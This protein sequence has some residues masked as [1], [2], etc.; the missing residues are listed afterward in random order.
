M[1]YLPKLDDNDEIKRLEA[2]ICRWGG[3]IVDYHEAKSYQIKPNILKGGLGLSEFYSG[4]VYNSM[5]I[6]ES[7]A[8]GYVLDSAMFLLTTLDQ[9]YQVKT[10]TIAKRKKFTIMEGVQMYKLMGS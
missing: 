1:F 4:N 2:L 3:V 10:I 6:E 9:T 7:I 5:W 8:C